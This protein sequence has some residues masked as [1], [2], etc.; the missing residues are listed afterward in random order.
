MTTNPVHLAT[1]IAKS[2][3]WRHQEDAAQEILVRAWERFGRLDAQGVRTVGQDTCMQV[4]Y[5]AEHPFTGAHPYTLVRH[6]VS[7]VSIDDE[8]DTSASEA[9]KPFE[10]SPPVEA[11]LG[12]LTDDQRDAVIAVHGQGLSVPEYADLA[13]LSQ[14]TVRSRLKA[15]TQRFTGARSRHHG[16]KTHCKRGHEFTKE[17]TSPRKDGGRD[18]LVCARIR[19]RK[20]SKGR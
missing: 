13:G 6:P 7:T 15:G 8:L 5:A 11:A 2:Y 17:N 9:P 12:S 19:A 1:K 4:R 10:W 16:E 3:A 14:S 20:A 18:C